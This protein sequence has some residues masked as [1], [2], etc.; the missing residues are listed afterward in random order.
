MIYLTPATE[1]NSLN[2]SIS[3]LGVE[4]SVGVHQA[5]TSGKASF[6]ERACCVRAQCCSLE[7]LGQGPN[8]RGLL[9]PW[10]EQG[11]PGR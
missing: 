8:S 3:H 1:A 11:R 10:S 9:F 6:A 4:G 7:V 5:Q 2:H